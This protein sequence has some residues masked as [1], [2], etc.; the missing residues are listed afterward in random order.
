MRQE[1]DDLPSS[2]ANGDY[3]ELGLIGKRSAG[4]WG[5]AGQRGCP[6]GI[7]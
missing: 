4:G 2:L 5:E 6:E 7:T 1:D 3:K